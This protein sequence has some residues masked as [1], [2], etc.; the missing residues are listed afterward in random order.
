[1]KKVSAKYYASVNKVKINAYSTEFYP[2]Y[3]YYLLTYLKIP[4]NAT[5]V[6]KDKTIDGEQIDWLN[7]KKFN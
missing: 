2:P 1:M 6:F 3:L 4:L 7:Q 5:I